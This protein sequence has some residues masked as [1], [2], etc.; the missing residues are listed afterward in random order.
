VDASTALTYGF[1]A[2]TAL[3][4]QAAE[5][6]R[7]NEPPEQP[8]NGLTLL[9]VA[10]VLVAFVI[11]YAMLLGLA[12]IADRGHAGGSVVDGVLELATGGL[13]LLLIVS[14]WQRVPGLRGLRPRAPISWLAISLYL[15]TLAH[16]LAPATGAASVASTSARPAGTGQLVAGTLPFAVLGVASVGPWVRRSL[17]DTLSRLGLLPLRPWTW[18]L[19]AALGVA[20]VK[21]GGHIYDLVNLLTPA[22]C[23]MQQERVFQQLAGS[24]RA[25]WEQ[26]AVATGAGVGEE[27]LFRGA[28]QPRVGM[29]L[30]SLL[31][32]SLHLQYTC[33]GLPSASNLYILLLGLLFG[34][35]RK[36]FGLGSAIVAHVTYDATILLLGS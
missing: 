30:A 23:R 6:E 22:D 32:A 12:E 10:R 8:R 2:A 11:V 34:A 16:N 36:W 18:L 28:L 24:H 33:H 17:P 26:L 3:V 35:L 21:G 5:R 15:L 25:W 19:G 27:V 31:W 7:G 9:D 20:A 13:S 1:L 4:C 14:G 29:L